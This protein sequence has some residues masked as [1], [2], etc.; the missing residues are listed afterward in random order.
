MSKDF[1]WKN[2]LE[3]QPFVN[4]LKRSLTQASDDFPTI[5]C[6]L[7][8][9]IEICSLNGFAVGRRRCRR[10]CFVFHFHHLRMYECIV[11]HSLVD[12]REKCVSLSRY[13]TQMHTYVH[14]CSH[15]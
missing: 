4:Y 13:F 15:I 10:F 6:F 3:F 14:I 7:N 1:V 12:L 2:H 5:H 11:F 8:E 9:M